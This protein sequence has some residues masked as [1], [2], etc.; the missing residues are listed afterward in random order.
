MSKTNFAS[1]LGM[2]LATAGA[3]VGLGNIWRFPTTA[4]ENG[5][6]VFIL[7]YIACTLLIGIPG[8]INEFVVG[9][10]SG[11]NA[12]RA[13][14]Q[15]GGSPKWGIVGLMG[16]IAS[17]VI[18][19]F[20]SVVAGW[21]A[22]Y[23]G[24]AVTGTL[25]ADNQQI[26]ATFATLVGN[27]WLPSVLCVGFI[28]ATQVVVSRGVQQGIER[29]AKMM[30]PM[31]F[32]LLLVVIA[33]SLTLPGA[34]NGVVFLLHPDFS[35][36]TVDV[37]FEALGQS[38]F[39]ICLGA[40]CLMTLAAYFPKGENLLRSSVQIALIDTLVAIMA[41]LMIF[42]AAFSVGIQPDAGPS[43][44]FQTLP[45][46]FAQAF[47]PALAWMVSVLFF[48]LLVLAAL[49]S[50]ISMHELGT[51]MVS[52][53]LHISRLR[54]SGMVSAAAIAIGVLSALSLGP[55]P[56]G[57]GGESLFDNFDQLASNTLLPMGALLTA[58]MVGWRMPADVLMAELTSD[59]RYHWPR[60]AVRLY[61]L[62]IRYVTPTGIVIVFLSKWGVI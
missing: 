37:V 25:P 52:Q 36:V 43:L 32:V 62:T 45:L 30:M 55:V 50:T 49:T 23:L 15:A 1:R 2:I 41:G 11:Q 12:M 13:S 8:M 48:F 38:F 28:L 7:I 59:G 61:L 40:G 21:C 18:M 47:S 60:W 57:V 39:S 53:E 24:L 46:V 33:T 34:W 58:I 5:G 20:Y 29:S 56:M 26:G 42:P 51:S 17:V 35:K 19:G 9:R 6:A 14:A 44:I 3:A 31:L 10:A 16:I 4:G 27:P 22:Y 54:A